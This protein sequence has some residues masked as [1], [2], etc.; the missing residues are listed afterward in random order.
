MNIFRF[1]LTFD[2]IDKYKYEKVDEYC[3]ARD[4]KA[5]YSSI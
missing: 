1:L 4:V 5:N 3:G 2:I